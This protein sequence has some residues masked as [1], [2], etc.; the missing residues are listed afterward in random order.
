MCLDIDMKLSW[1]VILIITYF[2]PSER[3]EGEKVDPRIALNCSDL[4][5]AIAEKDIEKLR[6]VL[7]PFLNQFEANPSE[8]DSY[9]HHEAYRRLVE[10]IDHCTDLKVVFSCYYCIL[11][12]IPI[13]EIAI[14]IE[15]NDHEQV[16]AIHLIP[17]EDGSILVGFH[18]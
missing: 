2:I 12:G 14:S 10:E 5:S 4:A 6:V 16:I 18:N 11:T 9:G 7:L 1:C 3:K 8:M 15:G 13:S 17:K